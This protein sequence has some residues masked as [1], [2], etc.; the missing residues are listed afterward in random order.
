LPE[1]HGCPNLFLPNH[2]SRRVKD[3]LWRDYGAPADRDKF[4]YTYDR[5]SNRL[6]RENTV[7]A[8]LDGDKDEI[9]V[10]DREYGEAWGLTPVGN[11]DGFED[12]AGPGDGDYV[13]ASDLDQ[14]RT[15]NLVNEIDTNNDHSDGPDAGAGIRHYPLS[16]LEPEPAEHPRNRTGGTLPATRGLCLARQ[17]PPRRDEALPASN[18]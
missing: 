16:R 8:D 1:N 5:N 17:F 7:T 3:Q 12:D 13:D 9:L 14:D 6:Y 11:W 18:G 4:T 15:H 10:A 2:W